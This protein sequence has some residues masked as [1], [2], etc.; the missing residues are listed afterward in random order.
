M[1]LYVPAIGQN[2]W[3]IHTSRMIDDQYA[4]IDGPSKGERFK[5]N[6]GETFFHHIIWTF[7]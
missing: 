2:T 6:R 3:S 5:V 4:E 7:I 1:Y